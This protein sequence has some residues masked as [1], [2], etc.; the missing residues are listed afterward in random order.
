M[1]IIKPV[2]GILLGVGE[3]YDSHQ[4]VFIYNFDEEQFY[5]CYSS[6][7]SM[8]REDYHSGDSYIDISVSLTTANNVLSELKWLNISGK[9]VQCECCTGRR[10]ICATNK[11]GDTI[12]YCHDDGDNY[13]PRGSN[14]ISIRNF[15]EYEDVE[16]CLL[17]GDLEYLIENVLRFDNGIS[18]ND[19]IEGIVQILKLLNPGIIENLS[20]ADMLVLTI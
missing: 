4:S 14:D 15:A 20:A 7:E 5:E 18:Q 10:Y 1:G 3:R 17:G 12:V 6:I 16:S 9:D 2:T 13:Y 19:V 8:G 11:C